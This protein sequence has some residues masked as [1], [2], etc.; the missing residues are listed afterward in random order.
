MTK[1]LLKG[2]WAASL[3]AVLA[4]VA[5]PAHAADITADV[6]FSFIV[7]GKTLP[8]GS[9]SVSTS[10][11]QGAVFV[12]GFDHGALSIATRLQASSDTDPK[13]VFYK[14]GDQYVLRQVWLGGAEGRQLP[15]T[16]L[17][18]ELMEKSGRSASA[19]ER[20]VVPAL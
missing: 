1:R 13:L 7:K 10:M 6:P 15:T 2:F 18:R 8:P 9:Y 14:Y 17:E 19:V 16:R 11:V 5:V 3:I 12:R 4:A 20:V